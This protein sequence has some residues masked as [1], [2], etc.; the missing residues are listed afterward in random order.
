MGGERKERERREGG[1]PSN[2][3]ETPLPCWAL[4]S[5][6]RWGR[7]AYYGDPFYDSLA[8]YGGRWT[9]SFWI[10]V[11]IGGWKLPPM[12]GYPPF[13]GMS[14]VHFVWLLQMLQNSSAPRRRYSAPGLYRRRY[15]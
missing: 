7:H 14:L 8:D 4:H 1:G 13:F 11:L 6:L 5:T 10:L 9:W 15:W 3:G 2:G 12:F